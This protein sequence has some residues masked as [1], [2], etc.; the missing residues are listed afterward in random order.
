MDDDKDSALLRLTLGTPGGTVNIS[1]GTGITVSTNP[2]TQTLTLTATGDSCAAHAETHATVADP[3]TPEDIGAAGRGL[4]F[5]RIYANASP[6]TRG[7]QMRKLLQ[8]WGAAGAGSGL[9]A[10][11]LRVSYLQRCK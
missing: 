9:D 2:A 1:A 5:I 10:D 6:T 11:K 3:I 7:I 8:Q 4:S